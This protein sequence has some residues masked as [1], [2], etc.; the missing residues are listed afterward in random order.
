MTKYGLSEAEAAAAAAF[1]QASLHLW[2]LGSRRTIFGHQGV[3]LCLGREM[4]TRS[5][6]LCWSECYVIANVPTYNL[7]LIVIFILSRRRHPH[8]TLLRRYCFPHA[9]T[10]STHQHYHARFFPSR[11]GFLRPTSGS[12]TRQSWIMIMK[13]TTRNKESSSAAEGTSPS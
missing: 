2:S 12:A 6:I 13:I 9:T 8:Q 11:Y 7:H 1:I 10:S 3:P 4:L 5:K